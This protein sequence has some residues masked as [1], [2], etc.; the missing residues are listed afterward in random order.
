MPRSQVESES[1]GRV[2]ADMKTC[3]EKVL[4]RRRVVKDTCEQWY[5]VGV[6]RP[7][8]GESSSQYG[9]CISTVVEEGQV[10]YVPVVFSSRMVAGHSRHLSSPG[11]EKRKCPGVRL[12][13]RVSLKLQVPLPVPENALWSMITLLILPWHLSLPEEKHEKVGEI[14]KLREFSKVEYHNCYCLFGL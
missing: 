6:V 13:C 2:L 5:A 12:I 8:S 4:D 1:S 9:V 3:F 11:K 10:Q 14:E 7:S